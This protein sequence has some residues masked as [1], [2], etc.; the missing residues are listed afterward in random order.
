MTVADLARLVADVV[1][2]GLSVEIAGASAGDP[3]DRY[4]PDTHRARVELGLAET[5]GLPEAIARTAAWHR[6]ALSAPVH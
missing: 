4:V 2:P 3:P 5:V 1:A 6:K